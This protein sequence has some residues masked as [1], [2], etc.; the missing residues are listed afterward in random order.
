MEW[1]MYQ[2]QGGELSHDHFGTH[3]CNSPCSA[4]AAT[5][6]DGVHLSPSS[7]ATPAGSGRAP[8]SAYSGDGPERRTGEWPQGAPRTFYA[9][10]AGGREA[11]LRGWAAASGGAERPAR[12]VR[13]RRAGPVWR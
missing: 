2:L 13:P 12:S 3:S 6:A 7:W 1:L 10:S 4:S 11:L 8:A 9:V 5:E